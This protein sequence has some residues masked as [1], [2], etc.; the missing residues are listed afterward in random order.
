MPM[1]TLAGRTA[2]NMSRS[3]SERGNGSKNERKIQG[4]TFLGAV[5]S[6]ARQGKGAKNEPFSGQI[7]PFLGK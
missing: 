5:E 1:S 3:E 6:G 4:Q 7:M 2:Q